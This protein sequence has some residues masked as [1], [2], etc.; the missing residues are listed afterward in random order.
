M[1]NLEKIRQMS[2]REL[3]QYSF[4]CTE[5]IECPETYRTMRRCPH[6]STDCVECW[7]LWLNEEAAD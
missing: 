2:D 5:G 7:R 3:A 4:D 1:T 6:G